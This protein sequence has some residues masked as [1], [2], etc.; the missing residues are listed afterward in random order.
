MLYEANGIKKFVIATG[1]TDMRRGIDGLCQIIESQYK[2]NP[3]EKDV[4]FL[5]CGRRSDRIK[6]LLWEGS[7]FLLLY[8]RLESGS[9]C[10]P[11]NPGEAAQISKNQYRLL[12]KG[13]NPIHPKVREVEPRRVC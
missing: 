2:L 12:L 4:L 13:L 1:Y 7:G 8:K 6:A 5:F 3:F 9:L 11:R 10:W